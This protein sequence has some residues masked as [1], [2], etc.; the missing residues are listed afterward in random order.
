M[1][2][3]LQKRPICLLYRWTRFQLFRQI[4]VGYFDFKI[5]KKKLRMLNLKSGLGVTLMISWPLTGCNMSFGSVECVVSQYDLWLRPAC[6][7]W[8]R[9]SQKRNG[10]REKWGTQDPEEPRSCLCDLRL[11]SVLKRLYPVYSSVEAPGHLGTCNV[12]RTCS[13]KVCW[14]KF[15]RF[16]E[17]GKIFP[18]IFRRKLLNIQ[19]SGLAFSRRSLCNFISK[20]NG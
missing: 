4:K 18:I 16:L 15:L 12:I 2:L 11:P 17:Y 14:V 9:K 8:E 13:R 19:I 7:H 5:L 20:D 6:L 3:L 1:V 10:F